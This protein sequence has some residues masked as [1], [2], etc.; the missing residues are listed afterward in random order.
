MKQTEAL[1]P[2]S[3]KISEMSE[4]EMVELFVEEERRVEE[5]LANAS[6]EIA[7]L[8]KVCAETFKNGG[9]LFYIGAGTSGRLGILDASECPPTFGSDPEMVQGIIAGG[10]DAIRNAV[11]GAED[12]TAAAE[13][14]ITEKLT[15]KDLLVGIS[16]S[17]STPFVKAALAKAKELGAKTAAIANN[18]PAAIFDHADIKIFLDTGAELLAGSTRLKAGSSQKLCL[19]IIT[20]C[21]LIK[22]GKSKSNLM[23]HLQAKNAKLKIRAKEL[24][25]QITGIDEEQAIIALEKHN[26][27]IEN[28]IADVH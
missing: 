18:S 15:R 24:L 6:K 12:D 19:N 3:N 25:M 2:K 22:I 11:E 21:S 17:G 8:I 5:A 20:T 26:Y 10:D 27:N 16:A 13:K 7:E 9:R 23:T 28:A 4:L 1:N 14:I